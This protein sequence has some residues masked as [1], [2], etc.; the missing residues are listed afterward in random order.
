MD[1]DSLRRMYGEEYPAAVVKE[2][3]RMVL[4]V[5]TR[6]TRDYRTPET[7]M[8][9][10]KYGGYIISRFMDGSA[11]MTAEQLRREWPT[12]KEWER[13]DFC[14]SS[15]WL[16]KQID[17]PEMLRFIMQHGAPDNWSATANS[18]A[19]NLPAEEAFLF[20]EGALSASEIGK[21]SNIIQ[22]IATTKHPDAMGILRKRLEAVWQHP[23]LW[24]EDDFCNWIAYE[25]ISCIEN[26][27]ELRASPTDFEDQVRSLSTHACRGNRDSCLRRFSKHYSWLK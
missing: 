14:Q 10:A 26:L 22:G 1:L 13:V 12:W 19:A 16:N 7:E 8:K 6:F 25:A 21:G 9:T 3:T 23:E 27:V 11:S 24:K 15:V 20:L 17:Y 5:E 18:I 4:A 2:G